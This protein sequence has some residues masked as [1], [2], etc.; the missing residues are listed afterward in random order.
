MVARAN[1]IIAQAIYNGWSMPLNAGSGNT[2]QTIAGESSRGIPTHAFIVGFFICSRKNRSD[3]FFFF[4]QGFLV[5]TSVVWMSSRRSRTDRLGG[6][7]RE[8]MIIPKFH[9]RPCQKI[10][11]THL[12]GWPPRHMREGSLSL[13]LG[14]KPQK[15]ETISACRVPGKAFARHRRPAILVWQLHAPNRRNHEIRGWP[16]SGVAAP[17]LYGNPLRRSHKPLPV[18]NWSSRS[19]NRR[20]TRHSTTPRLWWLLPLGLT[21]VTMTLILE[22]SNVLY[23]GGRKLLGSNK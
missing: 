1:R 4:F 20:Y 23:M 21:L 9:I 17:H 10:S 8:I 3:R 13:G 5:A 11:I 6:G 14:G 18:E 15:S 16:D 2:S 7:D 12:K 19:W 22:Q